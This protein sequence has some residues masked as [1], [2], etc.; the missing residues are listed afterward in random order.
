M[1]LGILN[2]LAIGLALALGLWL[3]ATLTLLR[4]PIDRLPLLVVLAAA[5]LVAAISL[6][7]GWITA[8]LQHPLL[9][10]LIWILA[11]V[12]ITLVVGYRAYQLSSAFVWL[13][14]PAL[15][16]QPVFP[17]NQARLAAII[18]SGLFI[19]LALAVLALLQNYRLQGVMGELQ[20]GGGLSASGWSRLLAPTLLALAAG[21]VTGNL[22]GDR[23]ASRILRDM[24]TA[25]QVA[26]TYEGDL[27]ARG[28]ED[29]INYAALRGVQDRLGPD[30]S[31][32]PVLTDPEIGQTIAAA[33]FS[34]GAWINCRFIY[35]QL[36]FCDDASLPYTL[37][38][39]ALIR[40]TGMAM[41]CSDCLPQAGASWQSWLEERRASLGDE[42]RITFVRQRGAHVLMQAAAPN[43]GDAIRC[44][45]SGVDPVQLLSCREV[46]P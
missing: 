24:D 11:A 29:G 32:I 9:T 34:N 31:L 14:E 3:P 12:L 45:F 30:Y 23:A 10:L 37:G 39:S 20:P 26:N 44:W 19:L 35:E 42:P 7:A 43:G 27:F 1:R 8:R 18:L 38:F 46:R 36:T 28:L 40:G 5:L 16:G 33:H 17:P 13:V 25:I 21:I 15:F 22:F 2:G 4:L 41:S 6:F